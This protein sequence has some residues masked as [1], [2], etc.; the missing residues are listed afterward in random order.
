[1][2]K[3]MIPVTGPSITKKEIDYITQ[4]AKDGWN[5]NHNKYVNL[6]EK[7][8]AKYV[9]RDYS[10][11]TPSCTAA[12]HL[13]YLALDL[14]EGDEVIV[15][16]IT[17]I[18]SV[19]PLYWMGVKPLFADIDAET[20]CINP[21][22][23]E[24][25]IT[26]KT[27]A[28]L[29]V[30]LYG[31]M[32]DMG[33]ILEI[34]K[35]HNLKIIEDAAE[36]VGSE[37][38]NKKAGSFGD[39]SCFSFHG[40]KTLTTGEGGMLL[41]NDKAIFDRA[42]YFSDH[43]KDPKKIFWNLGIGYKYKMS[44]FQAACGIAQLERVK[45]LVSKKRQIFFWYQKKLARI[46]GIKL[47]VEKPDVKNTYWMVTAVFDKKYNINREQLMKSL[48]ECNIQPRP[49]FYPLSLLPAINK[50]AN[51]PV[52]FD[53]YQRAINLPCGF[54]TTKEQVDYICNCL[55]KILDEKK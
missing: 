53:I 31:G 36:A 20:W 6:F 2:I 7:K 52:S 54:N 38:K 32:P 55:L 11:A 28:I 13:A 10:L 50:K 33:K 44:N 26:K 37:Y 47:N 42:K 43:C 40:S 14:K 19:E 18:A 49:F 17:W 9:K 23:I 34:A 30:D 21:I 1:M 15:P 29:L 3:K 51:T 41:T 24:K 5:E 8:F 22:A 46:D 12:L 16:N 4:A 35:K 25:K 27:K 39:V 48:E 45:E